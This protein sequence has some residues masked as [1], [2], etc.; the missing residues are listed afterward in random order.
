VIPRFKPY[1]DIRELIA[2]FTLPGKHDVE[3]FEQSFA[4]KMRQKHAITFPYGRTGLLVLLEALGL[5]NREI[6]CPA[7]TCV[8]VPHAIVKSG[9][10]PV[11]VDCQERDFNMDLDRVSEAITEKT[12]AIIPTS[13]FGYPVDL[14]RLDKIRKRYKHVKI[15]QDCA[16]SFDAEWKGRPVQCE[17]DAAIFGL[18][19]SKLITSIFGGIVTTN[20]D[21]LARNVRTIRSKRIKSAS[22]KKSFRRFLYLI[23]V[24]PTFWGPFYRL[25]NRL[26]RFGL[27]DRF[28]KYYDEGVIDMPGDYLEMMTKVEA[29]VGIVQICKYDEIIKK[30]REVAAFWRRHLRQENGIILPPEIEGATYSHFVC[31]VENRQEW[32]ERWRKYGIQLGQLIDYTIPYMKAYS[33]KTKKEFS[34]SLKYSRQIINFPL[35]ATYEQIHSC[36]R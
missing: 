20:D 12:G 28:T 23:V 8:V 1:L 3:H 4:E 34:V 13:I 30:R 6:I 5:Q 26:E 21:T 25:V 14:D 24:Y 16:H 7:Y 32:I 33:K 19:I 18:N 29:R 27:L 9:N 11:F 35:C 2:A 10:T 31:I 17:G 15:I 36:D 22:L